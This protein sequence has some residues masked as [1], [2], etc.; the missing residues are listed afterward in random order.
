MRL[1]TPK[2]QILEDW[3]DLTGATPTARDESYLPA[4]PSLS[5]DPLTKLIQFV[6][7]LPINVDS[8]ETLDEFQQTFNIKMNLKIF[9]LL[10]PS[11][12][13]MLQLAALSDIC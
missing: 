4:V 9:S 6:L 11:R 3:H 12:P 2:N 13:I 10:L 1:K 8:G 5:C 7:L